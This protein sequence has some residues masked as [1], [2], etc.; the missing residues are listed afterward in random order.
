MM[1]SYSVTSLSTSVKLV[2]CFRTFSGF[3]NLRKNFLHHPSY[4]RFWPER[5][6]HTALHIIFAKIA[7]RY[8]QV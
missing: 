2:F 4:I 6:S 8:A 7:T 5:I 1:S 3:S